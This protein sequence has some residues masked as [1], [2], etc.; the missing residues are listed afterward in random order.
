ML[1]SQ[2]YSPS[3]EF[4]IPRKFCFLTIRALQTGNVM[5][6]TALLCQTV[7]RSQNRRFLLKAAL[8]SQVYK[9]FPNR[10][11]KV[12]IYHL[13]SMWAADDGGSFMVRPKL[14]VS[15]EFTDGTVRKPYCKSADVVTPPTGHCSIIV[16]IL[17]LIEALK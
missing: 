2:E 1:H 14:T 3:I 12:K 15:N 13:G 6:A 10:Y 8:R 16:S 7:V 11:E 5:K 4:E 17:S 9:Y